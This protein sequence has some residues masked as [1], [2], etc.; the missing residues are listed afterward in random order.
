LARDHIHIAVRTVKKL[1]VELLCRWIKILW[2]WISS[3]PTVE[4][5]NRCCISDEM[6]GR[7]DEEVARNVDN[8]HEN[9]SSEYTEKGDC[10]DPEAM[11]NNRYM[12]NRL[13]LVKLNKGW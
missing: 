5:Y 3:E 11:A 1:I 7:E 9:V 10:E 12:V 2:R 6:D 8:K 13:A 4:R